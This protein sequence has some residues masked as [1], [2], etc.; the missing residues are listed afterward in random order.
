MSDDALADRRRASEEDYFRK[1][2][3]ELIEQMRKRADSDAAPQRLS[4]RVGVSD[5]DVLQNLETLGFSEETVS[6]LHILPLVYVA[7]IDGTASPRAADHII[8]VAR[9]HGIEAG[10]VA[11]R[12]LAEWLGSKP[13]DALFLEALDAI[14]SVLQHRSSTERR[15]YIQKILEHC[16]TVAAASGGVLGFGKVSNRERDALDHVRRVLEHE[17]DRKEHGTA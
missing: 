4:A 6:L 1:R 14:K 2:D 8:A 5:E 10:S 9:E 11:D 3:N 13:P 7:W 15:G 12:Q 16:T 17:P